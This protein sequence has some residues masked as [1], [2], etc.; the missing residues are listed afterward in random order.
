V[1]PQAPVIPAGTT[2]FDYVLLGRTPHIGYWSMESRSDV[3]AVS[4]VLDRLELDLLADRPM[5]RVSGGERQRAVLG[6]ALAQDAG[7][8]VLDEPTSALDL[9]HQQQVLE[10][11][12]S[13]RRDR[14]HAVLSAVHDLTL[15]A[16]FADRLV[17]LAGGQVRATGTPAEVLTVDTLS[18][19]YETDI[20]VVVDD[21]G[22]RVVAP[23]RRSQAL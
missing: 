8:L 18:E 1:V 12:D 20:T 10:L 17:L 7:L 6:R 19:F 5:D 4:A 13:L 15:A 2:V 21:D 11:V 22:N 3:L 14:G 9:G 23:R 16:Q